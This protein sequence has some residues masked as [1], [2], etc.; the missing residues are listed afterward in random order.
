MDRKNGKWTIKGTDK[1]FE[2]DFFTVYEDDVI[3]PDGSP[4]KYAT[5][6]LKPG[7]AVLPIDDEMNVYLTRQFRYALR[8]ENIEAVAGA[9]ETVDFLSEAKRELREELGIEADDW[10]DCG[11]MESDTSISTSRAYLFLARKLTFGKPDRESTEDIDTVRMKFSEA[12]EQTL[13]G[14][15]THG[16]T[17]VLIL[18][19][20]HQLQRSLTNNTAIK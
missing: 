17:C 4:G 1:P 9:A 13:S 8:R 12:L 5:I 10:T 11:L 3:Q 19:A 15:I 6:D 2:N 18:K 14:E 16:Q 7:V 20:S